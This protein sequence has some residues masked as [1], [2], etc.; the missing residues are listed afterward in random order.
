MRFG[1]IEVCEDGHV[2]CEDPTSL[3][4]KLERFLVPNQ[5]DVAQHTGTSSRRMMSFSDQAHFPFHTLS[6]RTASTARDGPCHLVKP[7]AIALDL[8]SLCCNPPGYSVLAPTIGNQFDKLSFFVVRALHAEIW[9]APQDSSS[10]QAQRRLPPAHSKPE[11]ERQLRPF[12][13][14][15][16]KVAPG[17]TVFVV[18]NTKDI[19][20]RHPLGDRLQ[21][22]VQLRAPAVRLDLVGAGIGL[23]SGCVV[24]AKNST[25][26]SF[27]AC[28]AK[29]STEFPTAG[30]ADTMDFQKT[31]PCEDG[32]V[33]GEDPTFRRLIFER[34]LLLNAV[35]LGEDTGTSSCQT[36]CFSERVHFNPTHSH[37]APHRIGRLAMD[38]CHLLIPCAVALRTVVVLL[39][40]SPATRSG[41]AK[42][43]HRFNSV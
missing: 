5:V 33:L 4:L 32:H 38:S 16:A 26:E 41:M 20:V 23:L 42:T 3:R 19:P 37:H 10:H 7:F 34:L 25:D 15:Y 1:K 27:F 30:G 29:S 14:S 43:G 6:P 35:D 24:L 18:A 40:P 39:Q 31:E 21:R 9:R 8:W 12:S 13:A 28:T 11:G 2:L 22:A 36:K 17:R